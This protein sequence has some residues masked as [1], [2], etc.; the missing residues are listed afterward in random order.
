MQ[1]IRVFFSITGYSPNK[2]TGTL[3]AHTDVDGVPFILNP[4]ISFDQAAQF[5][6]SKTE[7][8]AGQSSSN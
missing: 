2:Y 7:L 4:A 5:D 6:V 3:G 8:F 1:L